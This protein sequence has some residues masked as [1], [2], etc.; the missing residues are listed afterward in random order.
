MILL[1]GAK[2]HRR[3]NITIK[4]T[5]RKHRLLYRELIMVFLQVVTFQK[6]IKESLLNK[7]K[8][9]R[10]G[11]CS[12]EVEV[13][14]KPKK[15]LPN[16]Q[17]DVSNSDAMEVHGHVVKMQNEI[18][19]G[20]QVTTRSSAAIFSLIFYVLQRFPYL[21][22]LSLAMHFCT[23]YCCTQT[24]NTPSEYASKILPRTAFNKQNL[25]IDPVFVLFA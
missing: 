3:S 16:N 9:K 13:R 12:P 4:C 6:L 20:E 19:T 14:K 18:L 21:S 10:K 24:Q 11:C 7:F 2:M 22:K 15:H 23:F 1:V 17:P 8:N 25:I 5:V